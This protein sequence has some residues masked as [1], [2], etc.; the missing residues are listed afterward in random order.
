M[1]FHQRQVLYKDAEGAFRVKL[2]KLREPEMIDALP[3]INELL[4]KHEEE[5]TIYWI[6]W[7]TN[8]EK[9]EPWFINPWLD[10]HYHGEY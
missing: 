1:R 8:W 4:S 2:I 9:K 6:M 3:K 10:S 5:F 7:I